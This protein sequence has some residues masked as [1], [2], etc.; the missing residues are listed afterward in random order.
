MEAAGPEVPRLG[1]GLGPKNTR[2]G[3]APDGSAQTLPSEGETHLCRKSPGAA[4]VTNGQL[5]QTHLPSSRELGPSAQLWET[6]QAAFQAPWPTQQCQ[7]RKSPGAE[8]R[9]R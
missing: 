3:R 7:S 1:E 2:G 4:E 8:C 9:H 6:R 5:E